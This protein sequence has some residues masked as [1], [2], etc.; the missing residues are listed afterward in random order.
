MIGNRSK[1][2]ILYK[3]EVFLAAVGSVTF[4]VQNESSGK[5][6]VANWLPASK[7]GPFGLIFRTYGPGKKVIDGTWGLRC[8]FVYKLNPHVNKSWRPSEL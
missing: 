3:G 5:D 8:K 4:F 2:P 6:K 1:T 7:K